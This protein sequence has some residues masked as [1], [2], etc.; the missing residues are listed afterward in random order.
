[1]QAS[2]NADILRGMKILS[3]V[4]FN[5]INC[6]HCPFRC[7]LKSFIPIASF[8]F[9]SLFPPSDI[10]HCLLP[11]SSCLG[12]EDLNWEFPI[13]RIFFSWHSNWTIRDDAPYVEITIQFEP[14]KVFSHLFEATAKGITWREKQ[15]LSIPLSTEPLSIA[16]RNSPARPCM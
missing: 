10:P 9:P 2:G 14:S 12:S 1:M 8:L 3:I 11:C 7:F 4:P 5:C 15:Y 13:D 6:F 16:V